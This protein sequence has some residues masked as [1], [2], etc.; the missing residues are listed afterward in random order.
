MSLSGFACPLSVRA[1][2]ALVALVQNEFTVVFSAS[3]LL[4]SGCLGFL[5]EVSYRNW[6][7]L[8]SNTFWTIWSLRKQRP[9][10]T[11]DKKAQHICVR[12]R[13]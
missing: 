3:Q 10:T 7:L 5:G 4:L 9:K 2:S 11:A 6:G 1:S 12:K 13:S 8:E